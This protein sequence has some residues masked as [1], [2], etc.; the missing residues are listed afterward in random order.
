MPLGV[1]QDTLRFVCDCASLD[2]SSAQFIGVDSSVLF[3]PSGNTAPFFVEL[4]NRLTVRNRGDSEPTIT[5]SDQGVYT[6]RMP[7]ENEMLVDVNVGI[8]PYGFNSEYS[9]V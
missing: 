1:F 2:L 4:T 5:S 9:K 8:Y 6:C 3:P 7:D